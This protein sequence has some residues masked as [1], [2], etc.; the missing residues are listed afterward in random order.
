ME[1]NENSDFSD[2]DTSFIY[3]TMKRF[4]NKKVLR[5]VDS[6]KNLLP[7]N[8]E[9]SGK[10]VALKSIDSL[11][12]LE[13]QKQVNKYIFNVVSSDSLSESE[14]SEMSENSFSN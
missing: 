2:S 14:S 8:I 9:H 11:K 7:F 4:K 1:R 13:C 5:P 10:E 3:T 6:L 12:N